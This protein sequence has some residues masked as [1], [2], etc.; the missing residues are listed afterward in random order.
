MKAFKK[1]WERELDEAVPTL[2]EEIKNA[3]IEVREKEVKIMKQ[4]SSSR[5]RKGMIAIAACGCA[6]LVG[7]VALVASLMPTGKGTGGTT[8]NNQKTVMN[9]S[10]NPSVEFVLD[11]DDKVL[12]VNALNE[13]GNLIVSAEVF[14]GK[15]AD[16]AAKLFAQ[17]SKESGFLVSGNA[18][19]AGNEL[20]VSFSGDTKAATELYNQVTEALNGYFS[21]ENIKATVKQ[22][23]AI[24]EEQLEKLVGE[25]MPYMQ[26]AQVKALGYAELV[27]AL[28]ESRKETAEFYSQELKNAYYEAK[29]YALTKAELETLKTQ[30]TGVA[31]VALGVAYDAYT[32][33][34]DN[35]EKVRQENLVAENSPYQVALRAF[36]EAKADYLAY[37]AEVAAMEQTEITST[38]LEILENYEKEV[39]RNEQA[40]LAAG[41]AANK[42]IDSA[43]EQL[44]ALYNSVIEL[45]ES[46]SVEAADFLDEISAQQKQAAVK[47]FEDFEKGHADVID[48][49]KKEWDGMKDRFNDKKKPQS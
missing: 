14:V 5:E 9:I 8:A 41:D 19:V 38:V 37:R 45:I 15:E 10:L 39:D 31:Q 23:A 17:A 1:R 32:S 42:A 2:R 36:R 20:N 22:A 21:E 46:A 47:F 35:I 13:E 12:S 43:K 26:E 25:C 34:T 27:D 11:A 6:L 48:A 49:A 44:T 7:G 4:S 16:E 33:A 28:C 18:E 29:A 24:T 40:L 3:P 30:V